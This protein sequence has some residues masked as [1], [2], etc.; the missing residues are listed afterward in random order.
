MMGIEEGGMFLASAY[1]NL[2]EWHNQIV[3]IIISKNN[4]NGILNNYVNLL[5]EEIDIQDATKEEII[6]IDDNVYKN[7]N[8]LI[9]HS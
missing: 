4:M 3:N 6:N 5:E 1:Q 7:L 8:D 9:F 2:I